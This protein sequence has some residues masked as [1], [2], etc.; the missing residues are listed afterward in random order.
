[1]TLKSVWPFGCRVSVHG[2]HRFDVPKTIP[3]VFQEH[4]DEAVV[5]DPARNAHDDVSSRSWCRGHVVLKR[6]PDGACG[7]DVNR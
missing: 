1:M 3:G 2:E 4:L 7:R 6:E 5:S